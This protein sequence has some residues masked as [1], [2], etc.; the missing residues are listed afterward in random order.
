MEWSG[1]NTRQKTIVG[2]QGKRVE[3]RRQFLRDKV[4]RA[5]NLDW[6]C[7]EERRGTIQG[8]VMQY[9]LPKGHQVLCGPLQASCVRFTDPHI[10]W[11]GNCTLSGGE[12][13]FLRYPESP[14][15]FSTTLYFIHP[16]VRDPFVHSSFIYR[17]IESEREH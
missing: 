10:W 12:C 17:R 4:P 7:L 8:N 16:S 14:L 2:P 9:D 11:E 15:I 13:G 5:W 3:E 1:G 6:R